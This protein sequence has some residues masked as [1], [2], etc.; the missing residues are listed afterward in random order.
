[1]CSSDGGK[2]RKPSAILTFQFASLTSCTCQSTSRSVLNLTDVL[3]AR[4]LKLWGSEGNLKP[5]PQPERRANHGS[6]SNGAK[7]YNKDNRKRAKKEGERAKKQL[8]KKGR[9][10]FNNKKYKSNEIVEEVTSR[11]FDLVCQAKRKKK[12]SIEVVPRTDCTCS[13]DAG[14]GS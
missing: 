5:K 10:V 7:K 11:C 4:Q 6:N 1:M 13:N 14:E 9:C 2:G 12:G 3:N 8:K